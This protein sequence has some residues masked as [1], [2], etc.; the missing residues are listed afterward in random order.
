MKYYFS[1]SRNIFYFGDSKESYIKTG[2]WSNDSEIIDDEVVKEFTSLPPEG[3][4]RGVID[5]APAWIDIPPLSH[6]QLVL[7]AELQRQ[8]LIDEAMQSINVIQLKLRAER[9]LT[10]AETE[11]LNTTLDYIDEVAAIDIEYA[12]NIVWPQPSNL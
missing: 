7:H 4:M 3:K 8:A 6:E 12:P 2:A 11:K 1:P 5:G 10:P 9:K